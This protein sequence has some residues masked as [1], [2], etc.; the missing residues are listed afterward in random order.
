MELLCHQYR[1]FKELLRDVKDVEVLL[2]CG[3]DQ[4]AMDVEIPKYTHVQCRTDGKGDS[5]IVHALKV[6]S[7]VTSLD[8]SHIV[9]L[10]DE[11]A[12]AIAEHLKV[13]TALI[14][15]R[16]ANVS[17]RSKTGTIIAK[18]LKLGQRVVYTSPIKGMFFC[19]HLF[20]SF[21]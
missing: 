3:R 2:T 16:L 14:S 17:L 18:A 21:L 7:V 4:R 20:L 9:E 1:E 5:F 15:L 11:D 19:L 13:N 10:Q 6:N 12:S 8:L